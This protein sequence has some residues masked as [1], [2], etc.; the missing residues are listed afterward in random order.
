MNRIGAWPGLARETNGSYS[1]A[2]GPFLLQSAFQP[3]FSQSASGNL[4]LEAYEAL[5]R[6]S[7]GGAGVPP[8]QFFSAVEQG[9]S[10]SVERLCRR[11][12]V[13]NAAAAEIG[14]ALVFLNFD[15]AC[16]TEYTDTLNEIESFSGLLRSIGMSPSQIVCE[17]TEKRAVSLHM[18]RA[19]TDILREHR[20]QIAVDDFG[21]DAS[22][23]ERLA[24]LK[25][26]IVK[27]DG[28]WVARFLETTEGF[29]L[30]K[31]MVRQFRENGIVVLFEGLEEHWQVAACRDLGVRLLQGFALATPQLLKPATPLPAGETQ[32][33][34]AGSDRTSP[35][36]PAATP[37]PA[38][39]WNAPRARRATFGRRT[40]SFT[41]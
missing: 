3:I 33:A 37:P 35:V 40:R 11:L 36:A 15:P 27:F 4:T 13:L 6:P 34:V 39:V 2:Y 20:F 25:P 5:V 14:G 22:D 9:D 23:S 1:A 24:H 21:A 19:L 12:H 17:I 29:N 7:R 18:L 28:N 26:N 32:G 41:D 16:F 31:V 38:G 30:L 10:T 8:P